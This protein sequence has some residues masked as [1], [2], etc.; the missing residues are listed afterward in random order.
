MAVKLASA[1]AEEGGAVLR[2]DDA[3]DVEDAGDLGGEVPAAGED[4]G[5][6]AVGDTYAV[7]EED[8]SGGELGREL[9]VVGGDQDGGAVLG[10]SRDQRDE[11]VLAA[12]VHS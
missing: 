7:A 5:G 6:G 2:G 11:I 9:D 3:G 8:D 4:V 10:E 1:G 12:A